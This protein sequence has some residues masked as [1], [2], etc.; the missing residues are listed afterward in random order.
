MQTPKPEITLVGAGLVGSLLSIYL[1]RRGWKVQIHERRADMRRESISGG[2]SINLAIS[3][4]GFHALRHV[5]LEEL[6][7][8]RAIA[9]RG[10]MLHA[11]DGSTQMVPYGNDPSECIFSVSRGGLN[12]SLM[13]EAERLGEVTI[14]FK[15]RLAEAELAPGRAPK[16]VFQDEVSGAR[17][18]LET[19]VIGTDGSAS[20]LREALMRLKGAS[21]SIDELDF[22]YKELTIPPG[23]QGTHQME[24]HAL[25]I[26]PRGSYMLI[27]LPN[28]DGSFTCTLFLPF[29][30]SH[31]RNIPGFDT[32]RTS[33]DVETFFR[34]HFS[35]ALELMPDLT[36]EFFANPTS[37]MVTVKASPWHLEDQA[38][39]LGDAAHA[40]VPFFGQGMN[41]GFEDV[42]ALS[43]ALGP[44][45]ARADLTHAFAET[46][47]RRKANSDA[48]ADLACENFV[49]MRDRVA[50]PRFQLERKVEKLIENEIPTEYVSRYRLVSFTRVPYVVARQAGEIQAQI[51]S[52]LTQG[53][54]EAGQVDLAR[55]VTEVRARLVPVLAP[56]LGK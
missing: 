35:D 55:A 47:E 56:Y 40:I 1:A 26:W 4:R 15:S 14:H 3:A 36:H 51:L 39:I 43:E 48:I 54:T 46:F 25:H 38:L 13:T 22:G 31:V 8:S 34:R 37:K 33:Y 30:T 45:A 41:A 10:R 50:D 53:V 12:Q 24:K 29:V 44:N 9:M 17:T 23:A 19:R 7:R 42:F 6:V 16:L 21:C 27:A 52:E 32:L 49:E 20:V 18:K 28:L 11:V 5:G 2:R